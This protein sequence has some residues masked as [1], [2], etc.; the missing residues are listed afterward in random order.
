MQDCNVSVYD[1]PSDVD[2]E[3]FEGMGAGG[4]VKRAGEADTSVGGEDIGAGGMDIDSGGMDAGF[5]K[6]DVAGRRSSEDRC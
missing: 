2:G 6:V 1:I 3:S 5:G 4:M